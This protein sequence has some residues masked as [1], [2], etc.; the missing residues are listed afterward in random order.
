MVSRRKRPRGAAATK[1]ALVDAF[2]RL[3]ARRPV[4]DV[5]VRDVAAAARVNHGLV[6]RHFG[7]KEGLVRAAVAELSRL[8]F[9]D[10]RPGLT[11]GSFALLS[12]HPELPIIVARC[13]L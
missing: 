9:A 10:E 6:H 5:S 2:L 8:A 11:A 13:C 4:A 1:D 7:S 12:E 3:V